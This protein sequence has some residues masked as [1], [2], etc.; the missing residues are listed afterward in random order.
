MRSSVVILNALSEASGAIII[1]LAVAINPP[2]VDTSSPFIV[3]DDSSDPSVNS[4]RGIRGVQAGGRR[5]EACLATLSGKVGEPVLVPIGETLELR[6][7]AIACYASQM[8]VIFRFSQDFRGALVNFAREVGGER[9]P[10]ERCW[11][12]VRANH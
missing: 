4:V 5:H 6:L 9:G 10:A 12:I 11:P 2:L 3:R 8:P 1:R 7:K